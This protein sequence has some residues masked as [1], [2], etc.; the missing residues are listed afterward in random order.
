VW[1]FTPSSASDK[2]V[3]VIEHTDN[4]KGLISTRLGP[5]LDALAAYASGS[6]PSP[7]SHS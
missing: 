5:L 1:Q 7:T 2:I 3:A 4:H 6:G